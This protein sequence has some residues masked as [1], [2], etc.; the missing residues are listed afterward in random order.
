MRT[1][2]IEASLRSFYICLCFPIDL[3]IV[4]K[5]A[6]AHARLIAPLFDYHSRACA[7]F[8]LSPSF[9][10]VF[11]ALP[12]HGHCEQVSRRPQGALRIGAEIRRR[13][14]GAS[15]RRQQGG[16]RERARRAPVGA[17]FGVE[18][19]SYVCFFYSNVAF[20]SV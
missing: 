18:M 19:A 6:T 13:A 17:C 2:S 20:D 16:G 3:H 15:D 8:M 12:G 14:S 5:M 4:S 9:S 11:P 10:C 7:H 1:D